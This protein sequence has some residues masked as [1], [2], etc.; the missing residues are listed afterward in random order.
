M[1]S[2]YRKSGIYMVGDIPWGTHL[3]QFYH[4]KEDLAEILVPYFKAGLENNEYCM[5]VTSEPLRA[6]EAEVSLREKV[7]NLDDYIEKGQIEIL[8]YNEWYTKAG[9]FESDKT[10]QGWVEKERQA[11]ENGFEGLRLTGNTLWLESTDW[12]DFTEYEAKVDS[13]LG[14]HQ[15]IAICTYSR[16]RCE[17]PE[18]LDVVS[19]H[20][21]ALI[22]RNGKWVNIQS[23]KQATAEEALRE[24]EEKLRLMFEC[25]TAGI[26]VLDL[27][28]VIVGGNQRLAEMY[29]YQS[30]NELIGRRAVDVVAPRERAK[31]AAD[32]QKIPNLP[33]RSS[34]VEVTHLRADDTEFPTEITAGALKDSS[35]SPVGS[36]AITTDITKRKRM[37]EELK[38]SEE[39]FRIASQIASDVVYERDLQTGIATFYGDIDSHLG[40][41]PGGYPRTMEGWR[42]HVHPEDLAWFDSQSLD[43]IKPGEKLSIEYR[44]R[45]KDGTYMTWLDQVVMIRDEKTGRPLKFIGAATDIT[46]RKQAEEK[47]QTIT[48]TALDGFWLCDI[49]GRFLE[50]NNSYCQ[51]IGYTREELLRMSIQDVEAVE[52]PEETTRRIEKIASQGYDRF[53]SRHKCKDGKIID[54]EVSV[55]Y[56]DVGEGQFFVFVRDI[57][58]RKRAEEA[59]LESEQFNASLLENAPNAVTVINTDTSIKY[60]NPAFEKLT[61]YTS[62][63]AVGQKAPHP[64]WPEEIKKTIATEIKETMAKRGNKRAEVRIQRK[65]G[66]CIWVDMSVTPLIH[67]QTPKYYLANWVDITERKQAEEALKLR[68]Q[69][70][71]SATDSIFLH[72]FDKNFIYVNETACRI[73]GYSREEFMKMKLSQVVAPERVSRLDSEFQEMLEKEQAIFESAHL[74]KDGSIMPAEVHG[75]T[76]DSGGKKLIL[77]VIRDITERKQAEAERQKLDKLESLGTLAGGIAHDFN[78]LLTGIMGNITLAERHIEPEGKAAERL[79]E[80][81]KA[82][83]RARDLTQQLLTFAKGGAPIMITASVAE[84]T[85]QAATFALRG[86]RVKCECLLPDDLWPVEIDEG[87]IDQVITNL[88]INADEAMPAGGILDI[89]AKNVTLKENGKLP[90]PGGRY[91]RIDFRDHG[92]GIAKEH[93]DKIFEPYFTTKQKGSGLGLATV[94]SVIKGHGGHVCVESKLGA[95]TTFHVYLPASPEPSLA[96]KE[97]D[98]R[99]T[100]FSGKGKILIMDDEEMIREM[101]GKMLSMAGFEAEL[102]NDGAEAIKQYAKAQKSGQ[103]FDAVILDLTIPGGMGGIEALEKL[104]EIDPDAKAIVSS[105]Y[106]EDPVMAK[107]RK[108]GFSAVITKPYSMGEL[109]KTLRHL[110]RNRRRD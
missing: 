88:T 85:E 73:H 110:I 92:V 2:S 48:R 41:E 64:W 97:E 16:D 99:Q 78:N 13:M 22:R 27:N 101:L 74:R 77:T 102:T 4:T 94:Y 53:E 39:R 104:L 32:I 86:S 51:L 31:A 81:K 8:D 93:L 70:L 24:S 108:Y 30:I 66:E 17:V 19:N 54:V 103:P 90:L 109:E 61:G 79:Q 71:D 67:Q 40:Y 21:C 60:M 12:Q 35:G 83:L 18:I 91:V 106:S 100:S 52:S 65:S 6:E 49:H 84:L 43:Q 47:H 75:R 56:L 23:A 55:N 1:A 9:E 14:G 7:K 62:A 76:I 10:L 82:S 57:T 96:K 11:L 50:V 69:I 33:A 107:Y 36:I 89:E 59:L 105:G 72:D 29:G 25:I 38:E 45:K 95:G 44:M 42:E 28:G 20:Q 5:W 3:C 87:Q 37:E 26:S 63:E 15:I 80:A 46:E 68:A 34:G 58:E 98:E